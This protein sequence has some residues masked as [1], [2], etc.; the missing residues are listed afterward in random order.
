M[1]K[2]GDGKCSE[3]W[4]GVRGVKGKVRPKAC[5]MQDAFRP[6]KT[7]LLSQACG[8]V[9]TQEIHVC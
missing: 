6:M 5:R 9:R 4:M 3:G 2:I 8:C 1:E 7:P